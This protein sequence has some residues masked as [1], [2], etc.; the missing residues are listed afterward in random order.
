MSV[1][2]LL[3]LLVFTSAIALLH[4]QN[5]GTIT[6]TVTDPSG[7]AVPNVKVLVVQTDTNFE[8]RA[9]TNGEGIY[10]VQS[11]QPG[12]YRVTFEGAGFKRVVRSGVDLNVGVVLPVNATLKSA[13]SASRLIFRPK[14]L[15]SRRRLRLPVR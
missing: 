15:F 6:G 2:R 5:T 13:R 1:T 10:R 12:T 8:S 3:S 7:A 9:V 11:L 14:A 4:G